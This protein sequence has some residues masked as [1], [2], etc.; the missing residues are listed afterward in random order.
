MRERFL[1]L[2]GGAGCPVLL[3]I[4]G[5]QSVSREAF[6]FLSEAVTVTAFAILG[7][8]E[9]DRVIA[10]GRRGLPEPQCP[11]RYFSDEIEALAWLRGSGA[12]EPEGCLTDHVCRGSGS[13]G[14]AAIV[15]PR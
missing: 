9:V 3:E 4:T 1:A 5:V 11:S 8:T 10:H 6:R 13:S 14:P 7:C 12:C 2:T 15:L